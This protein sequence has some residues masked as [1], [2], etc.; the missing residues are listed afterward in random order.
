VYDRLDPLWPSNNNASI[1]LTPHLTKPCQSSLQNFE[2][3]TMQ[4]G[5]YNLGFIGVSATNITNDFLNWWDGHCQKNG[6]DHQEAGLFVD[7]KFCDLVPSIFESVFVSKHLGANVAYWNLHERK[8]S[9]TGNIWKVNCEYQLVFFHYS[10]IE[11]SMEIGISKHLMGLSLEERPDLN[12]L[13]SEY[14]NDLKRNGQTKYAIEPYSFGLNEHGEEIHEI[15]RLIFAARN[16]NN[17]YI[18][19]SVTNCTKS[20]IDPRDSICGGSRQTTNQL[21][22]NIKKRHAAKFKLITTALRA[23]RLIIGSKALVKALY[24][25]SR[26]SH[27]RNITRWIYR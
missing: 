20:A 10:G 1:V 15:D 21:Q 22:S 2:I 12:F 4:M 25:I 13:F 5:I 6:F 9:K 23:M 8:I 24:R 16:F 19:L 11:I 27:P 3:N 7:Q 17:P 18:S 26:Y 14:R